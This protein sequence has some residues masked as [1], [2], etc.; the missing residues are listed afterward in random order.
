MV[1]GGDIDMYNTYAQRGNL[2]V[3]EDV[4]E[5]G[6]SLIPMGRVRLLRAPVGRPHGYVYGR[7]AVHR[8]DR[9][10]R[11]SISTAAGVMAGSRPRPASGWCFAHLL[12]TDRPH[13]VATA[14]RLDRFRTGT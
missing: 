2:P 10:S 7:L 3:I 1:F 6:M 14:Y 5:S 12:A 4:V 13:H 8:Q 11:G 9:I